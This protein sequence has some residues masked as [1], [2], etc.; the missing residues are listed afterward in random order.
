MK[1][2]LIGLLCCAPIAA[3]GHGDAAWIQNGN[4]RNLSGA[5]E[6][7]CGINDCHKIL[8]SDV[9][10]RPGGYYVV[11]LGLLVP[12]NQAQV[13]EDDTFWVCVR[14]DGVMR[15]FFSPSQGV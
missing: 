7:C 2:L 10:S 8:R 12:Y 5:N 15:C 1:S 13:S 6:H 14:P 9:Q 11:S 4:Y 3:L